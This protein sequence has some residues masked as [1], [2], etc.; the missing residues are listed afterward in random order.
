M[1]YNEGRRALDY[2]MTADFHPIRTQMEIDSGDSK[3]IVIISKSEKALAIASFR[4]VSMNDQ[5][6]PVCY[7]TELGIHRTRQGLNTK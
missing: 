6:G 4:V 3:S 1:R 5:L 2:V 7:H